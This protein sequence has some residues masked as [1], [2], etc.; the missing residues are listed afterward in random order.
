MIAATIK[1]LK[2]FMNRLL[3]TDTFDRFSV[4][5]VQI[6]TFATFSIDGKRYPDFYDP[7][8]N[9]G[10][11]LATL[12]Q[13]LWGEVRNHCFSIIKGKHTPLSF[14]ITLL[15][16]DDEAELLIARSGIAIAPEDVFGLYLNCQYN[17]ETLTLTTGTSLRVFT[18]D[19]SLDQEWD[20][21]LQE[22]LS[23]QEIDFLLP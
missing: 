1:N 20:R 13:I 5:E 9:E 3:L 2:T 18:L 21:M 6:T 19:K 10:R 16:P 11:T 17:G 7:D 14:K 22:F 15:L 8:S 4:S 12:P 23:R